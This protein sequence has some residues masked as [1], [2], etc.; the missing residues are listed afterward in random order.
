MKTINRP[1]VYVP[2]TPSVSLKE[3]NL[4]SFLE[5]IS[6]EYHGGVTCLGLRYGGNNGGCSVRAKQ[7]E[8]K[9]ALRTLTL[10]KGGIGTSITKSTSELLQD[11]QNIATH[12]KRKNRRDLIWVEGSISNRKRKRSRRTLSSSV[13]SCD[14]SSH[15]DLNQH[16]A[17]ILFGLN[18]IWNSY[19]SELFKMEMKVFDNNKIA[20]LVSRAELVGASVEIVRSK[21]TTHAGKLGFIVDSSLN[22]WRIATPVNN[23]NEELIRESAASEWKV[24][25]LP[26]RGT[27]I[28]LKIP[29]FNSNGECTHIM[30]SSFE[31]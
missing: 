1:D 5:N 26:K 16:S 18:E 4:Y 19:M 13:Q 14:A 29:G 8:Q 28:I 3:K 25:T 21:S 2:L 30:V 20:T 11:G 10:I 22:V 15:P 23:G 12:T 17:D 31:A 6:E 9:I 27:D 24:I 7:M